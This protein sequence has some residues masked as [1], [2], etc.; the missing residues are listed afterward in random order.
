MIDKILFVIGGLLVFLGL[1]GFAGWAEGEGS[2]AVS[3]IVF[4]V[5]LGFSLIEFIR[6]S[7]WED[8]L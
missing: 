8:Y 3:A 4:C 7:E 5:G 2:F 6:G 1:S